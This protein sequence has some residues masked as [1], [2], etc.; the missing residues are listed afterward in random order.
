MGDGN[1]SPSEMLRCLNRPIQ[2]FKIIS[3]IDHQNSRFNIAMV[4]CLFGLP[5]IFDSTKGKTWQVDI[6][7]S[8]IRWLGQSRGLSI[9]SHANYLAKDSQRVVWI[10]NTIFHLQ[11]H[12]NFLVYKNLVSQNFAKSSGFTRTRSTNQSNGVT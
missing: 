12:R 8:I 9:K 6:K 5:P 3:T 2:D 7:R 4:K 10:G 11:H 1:V